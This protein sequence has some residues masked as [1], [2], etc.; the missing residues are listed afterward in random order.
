MSPLRK[1]ITFYLLALALAVL[2]RAAVP[3]FGEWILPVTMLTPAVA[4]A[5]MLLFIAPEQGL[6]GGFA[7]SASPRAGRRLGHSRSPRR[8]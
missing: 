5:C 2:V 1:A 4:V 3:L 7:I 6:R 8:C